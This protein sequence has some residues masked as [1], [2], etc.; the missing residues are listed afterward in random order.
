MTDQATIYRDALR[1]THALEVQGLQ[2]MKQQ[3]PELNDYP[4]YKAAIEQHIRTTEQQ[5]GRL[6]A[7]LA[8]IDDGRSSLKEA[9]TKVAGTVGATVHGAAGDSVLK[10]LFAGY[11]FQY[12]QIAAYRSLVVIAKAAGH[13]DLVAGLQQSIEEEKKAAAAIDDLIETVT[14]KYVEIATRK[15]AA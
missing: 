7:A 10:N 3:L 11:A 4:R 12:D 6:D 2:Q 5:I 8:K 14:E 13:D 1:S 9:V 15:A